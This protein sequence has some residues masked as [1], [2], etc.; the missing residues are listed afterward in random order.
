M[1]NVTILNIKYSI[2]LYVLLNAITGA[3][4]FD[5]ITSIEIF[6]S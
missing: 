5:S 2:I 6:F 1:Y 4:H 3:G